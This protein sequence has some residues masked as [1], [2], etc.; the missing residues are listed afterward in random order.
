MPASTSDDEDDLLASLENETESDPSIAHLREARLQQLASELKHSKQQRSEGYG[1]YARITDEKNLME[2]TTSTKFCIVHFYKPDF[3]RCRIMDGHLEALAPVHLHTRFL[4]MDVEHAP[5]L[6]TKLNVKVLPCV[7]AFVEGVSVD[8]I[9]GFEGV[10][11]SEDTFKTG[12][13]ERRL[14]G[15]GVL[16]RIKG[17]EKGAANGERIR[18][19]IEKKEGGEEDDDEW[20]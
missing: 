13:L 9:V 10:G 18:E 14:V 12:D 3:N 5:F 2:I 4:R 16:E 11:Y 15:C 6:V 19:R 1:T 20:D 8:R 7:I 17:I